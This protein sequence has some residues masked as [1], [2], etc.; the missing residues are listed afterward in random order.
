[1]Q[2]EEEY[3]L[4]LNE[5]ASF[6]NEIYSILC[7]HASTV[8]CKYL[9]G[10]V[11]QCHWTNP[12]VHFAILFDDGL[13]ATSWGPFQDETEGMENHAHKFNHIGVV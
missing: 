1:M 13:E 12:G 10:S 3:K 7:M 6:N 5:N 4:L 8:L 2:V 11:L 9:I